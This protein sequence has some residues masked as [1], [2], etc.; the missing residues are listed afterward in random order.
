MSRTKFIKK[1]SKRNIWFIV[2]S[3]NAIEHITGKK[4]KYGV[5]LEPTTKYGKVKRYGLE[6]LK[7]LEKEIPQHKG[8]CDFCNKPGKVNRISG[9]EEGKDY[10]LYNSHLCM[11]P[12]CA[13][14]ILKKL[15]EKLDEKTISDVM[16]KTV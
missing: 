8:Q 10:I 11:H 5:Y 6:S 16:A 1:E 3:K 15:N 13:R 7:I 4:I 2:W 14:Y 12:E 9:T